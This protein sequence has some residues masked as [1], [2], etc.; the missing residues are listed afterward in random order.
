MSTPN[1]TREFAPSYPNMLSSRTDSTS[2]L[3][4][5]FPSSGT[6]E[7]S[8][9]I[10]QGFEQGAQIGV[11]YDP[12]IAKVVAHGRDRTEALRVL[13]K[14]LEEYKVVVVSTNIEFLRSLAGNQAFIDGE[15]E[16]NFISVLKLCRL[17]TRLRC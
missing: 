17:F 13:R 12:M 6:V 3:P 10:E 9:R 16:T 8:L 4:A 11:Y 1:P 14:A 5:R 2:L 15:V 7:P